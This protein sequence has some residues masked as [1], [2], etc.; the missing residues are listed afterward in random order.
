MKAVQ[1][2][3]WMRRMRRIRLEQRLDGVV[4][5]EHGEPRREAIAAAFE[6][7]GYRQVEE[8]PPADLVGYREAAT[9]SLSLRFV[10]RSARGNNAVKSIRVWRA[11]ARTM[12]YTVVCAPLWLLQ[13]AGIVTGVVSILAAALGDH[14]HHPWVPGLIAAGILLGLPKLW[15]D[16]ARQLLREALEGARA[17]EPAAAAAFGEAGA[18]PKRSRVSPAP[19]PVRVATDSPALAAAAQTARDAVVRHETEDPADAVEEL[20]RAAR[21]GGRDD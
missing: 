9:P 21:R 1:W 18:E 5:L 19:E 10:A 6:R 8:P 20:E 11:D 16:D 14:A 4:V 7:A 3:A 12:G 15:I 2:L 17:G 13:A